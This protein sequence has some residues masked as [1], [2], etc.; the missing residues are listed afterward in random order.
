[1][2][3]T[4]TFPA[5]R[6][7]KQIEA[8]FLNRLMAAVER[9]AAQNGGGASVQHLMDRLARLESGLANLRQQPR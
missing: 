6:G 9:L 2:N 8:D 7:N 1:M 5:A 3:P 4:D